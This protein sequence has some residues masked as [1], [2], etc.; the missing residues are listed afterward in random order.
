MERLQLSKSKTEHS[1]MAMLSC[2]SVK[3]ANA[4]NVEYA[5]T[6]ELGLTTALSDVSA[7]GTT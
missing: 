6:Q 5:E 1:A 7:Y 2:F 4:G 3:T